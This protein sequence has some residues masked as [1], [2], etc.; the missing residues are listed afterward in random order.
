MK[1]QFGVYLLWRYLEKYTDFCTKKLNSIILPLLLIVSPL[2]AEITNNTLAVLVN[3]NDP[4]SV[5]IGKYYQASRFIPEHNII[6]LEFSDN[7]NSLTVD[8][9]LQVENQLNL[10]VN[11]DVQ[12]Y[13]LAWRKPWRVACM[14]I[15]S[16]FALGFNQDY[17]ASECK[18]TKL[19]KYYKSQS[20]NPYTDFQIR[21]AIM[22]SA[23]SLEGVKELI[24]RGVAADYS[25][26][27][28]TAYLVS[29]SDK[30]RNVRALDYPLIK[31]AFDAL[32]NVE[33]IKADAIKN[34]PDILFYFT[35]LEKI[36]WID[37]NKYLP[38]ALADHLTSTGG[39]LFNG[40]QMSV[41]EWIDAGV[42]G[43]Y[44][45]V[46]EPCNY[47]QK[48]PNPGILMNNYL[49]GSNLIES[50]WKSVQMPGQ[51]LF[52]GE[53]LANPYKG[54]FQRVSDTNKKV[55]DEIKPENYIL[56][57]SKNCN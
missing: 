23:N 24:D 10:Q 13:V 51:G 4:E 31:Q 47:R 3:K 42:T 52:V 1:L 8:E 22:L 18:T 29:T 39:H 38:G 43:T 7:V 49:S 11:S 46:T 53:P 20:V 2:K 32:I 45:T 16:A 37:K 57:T 30:Q 54:C 55:F 56:K 50:Y 21:P 40:G 19:V 41:L 36:K 28:A 48:F 34:K 25:R 33:L 35:G 44:G 9:F 27:K 5:E 6:Y 14:S 17:C 15:T 26:P 12:A